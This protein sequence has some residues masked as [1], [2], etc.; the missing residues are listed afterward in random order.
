M[1]RGEALHRH[2]EDVARA[3]LS[4]ALGLLLDLLQ[5]DARLSLRFALDVGDQELL[6]LSD[7]QARDLLQLA[8]L[9]PALALQLLG[10]LVQG[11]L[12]IRERLAAALQIRALNLKRL[13]L[14]QRALLHPGDLLAPRAKLLGQARLDRLL[15]DR[16]RLR[17]RRLGNL[18]SG[19]G[20]PPPEEAPSCAF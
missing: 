16:S 3:P 8:S 18:G 10:L 17:R 2:R 13:G 11:A 20:P 12:A 9:H 15:A 7:A 4:L 19:L 14:A 6:R 5:L 1:G